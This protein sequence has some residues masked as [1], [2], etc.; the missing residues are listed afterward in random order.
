MT[1]AGVALSEPTQPSVVPPFHQ[2]VEL[3]P[4]RQEG[5]LVRIADSE[6]ARSH[7]VPL[8]SAVINALHELRDA[9]GS[10]GT[11]LGVVREIKRS[12]HSACKRAGLSGRR[13]HDLR[14]TF[15]SRLAQL[16]VDIVSVSKLLGHSPLR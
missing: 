7:N 5:P 6:S 14:H 11:V 4:R 9:P 15:A 3:H 2:A 8:N 13:L 1:L 10:N 16:G 12:F